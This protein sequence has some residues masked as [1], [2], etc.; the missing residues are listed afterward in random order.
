MPANWD[1]FLTAGGAATKDLNHVMAH[2]REDA[3]AN[4][5]PWGHLGV[6]NWASVSGLLLSMADTATDAHQLSRLFVFMDEARQHRLPTATIAAGDK[7]IARA[8]GK[9]G[10][11]A[12]P[13]GWT[14]AAEAASMRG[15]NSSGAYWAS[16]ML[17]AAGFKT[18]Q[19]DRGAEGLS[20]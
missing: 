12:L 10:T 4:G 9:R 13:A 20:A 11:A 17:R 5:I 6:R 19:R 15:V 14:A 16:A 8:R 2:F 7:L 18:P 1:G 3:Y